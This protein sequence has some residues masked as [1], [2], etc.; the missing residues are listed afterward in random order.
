MYQKI[1]DAMQAETTAFTIKDSDSADFRALNL[2]FAPGGYTKKLLDMYP[3]IMIYGITLAESDG[4]HEVLV[5]SPRLKMEYL[6]MN[7]LAEEYGISLLRIPR[8]HPDAAKFRA[9]APFAGLAFDIVVGDGAVLRTHARGDYRQDKDCEALRLRVAQLIFGLRRIKAGGTFIILLHKVDS[10]ENLVLL[11]NF[12]QFSKITTFKASKIHT[13]S[14][15]FYLIAKHVQPDH[16]VAKQVIEKWKKIWWAITFGGENGT[17]Q[18]PEQPS[19]EKVAQALESYGS[20]YIELG[21]PVWQTQADGLSRSSYI[22]PLS[23]D[24]QKN[25]SKME[26][27]QKQSRFPPYGTDESKRLPVYTGKY[28]WLPPSPKGPENRPP[29]ATLRSWRS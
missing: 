25:M 10:W 13:Q 3:K 1:A 6:D 24:S 19:D 23:S 29:A 4:G 28:Q 9:D 27:A 21:S 12:E 11:R 5:K 18:N 8:D 2:C 17:G 20:R 14:S 22:E 26:T 7:L 15:S 16:P